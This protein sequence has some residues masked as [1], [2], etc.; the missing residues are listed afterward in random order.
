MSALVLTFVMAMTCPQHNAMNA[1]GDHTMG[2]SQEKTTHHF[3]L[4]RDGGSIEV[5]ANDPADTES[6]DMIR[7]HL[8]HIAHA[9]SEGDFDMPMFIHDQTPPGVPT[10][11]K[12][13]AQITYR[14]EESERGA[15]VLITTSDASALSAVH[16]FLRFQITD[17]QTGDPLEVPAKTD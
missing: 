2:F 3:L 17:H 9:F 8:Q 7:M 4:R 15:R 16:D 10:M 13:K 14:Y 5:S 11:Q 1:R 6:R 12:R